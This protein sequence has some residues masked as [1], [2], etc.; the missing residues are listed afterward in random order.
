MATSP[1]QPQQLSAAIYNWKPF[2]QCTSG[3]HFTRRKCDCTLYQVIACTDDCPCQH[4]AIEE[5]YQAHVT[6]LEEELKVMERMREQEIASGPPTD[7]S[8]HGLW[9]KVIQV[10]GEE[11][12]KIKKETE[13]ARVIKER[14]V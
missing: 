2:A 3:S 14:E 9:E 12:A 11:I 7:P 6:S 10:L 5:L 4:E 1:T 13:K 8:M